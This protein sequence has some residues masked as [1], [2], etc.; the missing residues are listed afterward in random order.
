MTRDAKL[1][2]RSHAAREV[3]AACVAAV[4]LWATLFAHAQ[5]DATAPGVAPPRCE[6][7][8]LVAGLRIR[9][10][11]PRRALTLDG[12][13]AVVA[14]LRHGLAAVR[15]TLEDGTVVEGTTRHRVAL[16]IGAQASLMGGALVVRPGAPLLDIVPLDGTASAEV[17]VALADGVV[18][19]GVPCACAA[20]R[21]AIPGSALAAIP[22]GADA[23]PTGP[24]WRARVRDL[25]LRSGDAPDRGEDLHIEVI[26]DGLVL[27]ETERHRSWV[28]L[29]ASLAGGQIAGWTRDTDLA[30]A[31]VDAAAP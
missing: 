25:H 9:A 22:P 19:R 24:R 27:V 14:P 11:S 28:R 31:P 3:A 26:H 12:V 4:A 29:T 21:P 20:L 6:I 5:D 16:E 30:P 13:V 17:D 10:R 7:S 8:G 15:A 23:A 2:R 1:G 18:A